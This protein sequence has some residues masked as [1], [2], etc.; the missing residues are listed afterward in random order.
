MYS[1]A[2]KSKWLVLSA[3]L[4]LCGVVS[5]APQSA[6]EVE[7]ARGAATAQQGSEPARIIG[8]GQHFYQGDVLTTSNKSFAVIRLDDGSRLTLRPNTQFVVEDINAQ[9]STR[10]NAIL[11]LFR[12]GVRAVTGFISKFNK[13]GYRLETPIAT[14]GIRGTEFDVR[15]CQG[16]CENVDTPDAKTAAPVLRSAHVAFARGQVAVAREGGGRRLLKTGTNIN[17][18]E[19]LTSGRDGIAVLVFPD[20]SRVTVQP[21]SEFIIRNYQY[22]K[23]NPDNNSSI[24]ELLRGGLR[25]VSG[26]IGKLSADKYE[27]RTPVA[28]IGIRGTGY[29]L[30]CKGDCVESARSEWRPDNLIEHL[31]AFLMRSAYAQSLPANGMYAYVWSGAIEMDLRGKR[32]RLDESQAAFLVNDQTKP[33]TLP[34]VPGFMLKNPY[35]KP[36]KV[37]AD[38]D[39]LF[40]GQQT[41]EKS[42]LYI[43][44]YDGE[45]E[46]GKTSLKKGDSSFTGLADKTT[47]RLQGVPDIIRNDPFPKPADFNPSVY[48]LLDTL[49]E[50][51]KNFECEL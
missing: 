9:R 8:Q 36:D 23:G 27:M 6:G 11:R 29:D 5:A 45:V 16:D 46:V 42:G 18:G 35:P 39:K 43:A 20:N 40:G 13:N 33:I 7:F 2:S 26:L 30:L 21:R 44:V 28:T 4:G 38:P 19:K 14:M 37:M 17:A 32:F 47:R 31:F 50:P 41:G 34:K 1:V 10:G 48:R 15:L 24:M 51:Q 22:D 49:D 3:L 25:A 12:G